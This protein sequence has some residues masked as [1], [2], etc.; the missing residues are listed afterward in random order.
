QVLLTQV[1]EGAP[2]F[3]VTGE[4]EYYVVVHYNNETNELE[5]SQDWV[6]SALGSEYLQRKT[7]EVQ[8]YNEDLKRVLER[9]IRHYNHTNGIHTIQ[10]HASCDLHGIRVL[11]YA[12][13]R[14]DFIVFE[15]QQETWRPVVQQAVLTKQRWDNKKGWNQYLHQYL[16]EECVDTLT[17]LNNYSERLY[18]Q[19]TRIKKADLKPAE[20]PRTFRQ[21]RWL[22][23]PSAIFVFL[24]PFVIWC[25]YPAAR[26]H[27]QEHDGKVTVSTQRLAGKF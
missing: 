4:L 2:S 1:S 21:Y 13:D 15:S 11:N 7:K 17:K 3:F 10:V 24:V 18:C 8:G 26:L 27:L 23:I 6:R 9:W 16:N 5:T 20:L 25:V 19:Q 14:K 22:I 12:Y